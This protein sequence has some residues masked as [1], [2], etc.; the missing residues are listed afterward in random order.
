MRP[1]YGGLVTE[2]DADWARLRRRYDLASTVRFEPAGQDER[3]EPFGARVL[4]DEHR[5]SILFGPGGP[6]FPPRE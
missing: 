4:C 3:G 1:W 6:M 2:L 5:A